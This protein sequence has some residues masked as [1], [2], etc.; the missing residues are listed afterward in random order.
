MK[1]YNGVRWGIRS[2]VLALALV[3][4]G[5]VPEDEDRS[6]QALFFFIDTDHDGLSDYQEISVTHTN[7]ARFDTDADGLSDGHEVSV[8]RTNP[9]STDTDADGLSDGF[10]IR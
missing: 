5:E 8:S 3:G 2:L 6:D 4:C 9:T 10:E 7:P 1:G